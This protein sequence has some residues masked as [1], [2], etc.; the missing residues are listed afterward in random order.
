MPKDT[1]ADRMARR[2]VVAAQKATA[3]KT[4][5][6]WIMTY[7]VADSLGVNDV[8]D[9]VKHAAAMGWIEIEREHSIR[10]TDKGRRLAKPR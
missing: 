6:S 8:D 2:L 7:D 4:P 5:G 10:L 1:Q 9:A 3:H